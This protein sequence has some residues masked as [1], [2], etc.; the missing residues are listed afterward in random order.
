LRLWTVVLLGNLAGTLLVAWVMLELPIFDSK[1]DIAFLDVGRKV[2]EN[3][4]ARCSPRAS[5]RAG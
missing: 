1:T 5:S 2:M 4:P 3:D